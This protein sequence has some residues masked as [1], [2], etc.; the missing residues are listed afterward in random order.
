MIRRERIEKMGQAVEAWLGI[1]SSF[2]GLTCPLLEVCVDV[3]VCQRDDMYFVVCSLHVLDWKGE[4]GLSVTS[5]SRVDTSISQIFVF[6]VLHQCLQTHTNPAPVTQESR[7]FGAFMKAT[8]LLHQV[9]ALR[10]AS[11][12]SAK[13][14]HFASSFC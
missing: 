12:L 11:K 8:N 13:R 6:V 9:I 3:D 7:T 4:K 10:W 2:F 5:L 1:M 14:E